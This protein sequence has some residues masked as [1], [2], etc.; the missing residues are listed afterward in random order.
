[1]DRRQAVK[2]L[3]TVIGTGMLLPETVLA[4]TGEMLEGAPP[5]LRFFTKSEKA[6][7]SAFAECLIPRTD[8]PGAIDAG[9]PGW[10]ELLVQDCYTFY[11]QEQ[12]RDGLAEINQAARDLY[13]KPFASLATD[14][15]IQTL[16]EME[17]SAIGI[18]TGYPGTPPAFIMKIK[19]LAKFTYASSERGASEAFQYLPIPGRYD[20][21]HPVTEGSKVWAT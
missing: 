12:F 21:A 3:G 4:R 17:R 6:I 7:V 14:A 13:G 2:A 18:A 9:V 11:E 20:G 19:D 5:K 15:Q 10:M 8:T 1:M 16:T